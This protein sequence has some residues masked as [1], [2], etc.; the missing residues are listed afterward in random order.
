MILTFVKENYKKINFY[1]LILFIF[2]LVMV[3]IHPITYMKVVN[4]Y[5][6]IYCLL[7]IYEEE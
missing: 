2:F 7:Y 3:I 6:A 5:A 1:Y 4:L